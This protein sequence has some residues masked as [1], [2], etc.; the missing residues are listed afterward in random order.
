MN[1]KHRI[2]VHYYLG[3]A[4]QD[5]AKAAK[6]AG[7]KRPEAAGKMLLASKGISAYL[8]QKL[9]ESGAMPVAE[10]LGRWSDVAAF[11][12]TEFLDFTTETNKAGKEV[13]RVEFNVK[14]LRKKGLGHLI[15]KMEF[16]PSGAVKLEFH[17]SMAAKDSLAKVNGLYKQR[18]EI[19]DGSGSFPEEKLYAFIT[20]LTELT[21]PIPFGEGGGA[22]QPG[23]IC[24]GG[25]WVDVESGPAPGTDRSTP[26]LGGPEGDRS[27]GFDPRPETRQVG[28]GVEILP[29]VDAGKEAEPPGDSGVL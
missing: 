14:K 17:D 23:Q 28:D 18:I 25:E 27:I 11:D 15:K 3:E 1:Y 20:E 12:P 4:K 13:E 9:E 7:Y 2:F 5:A 16:L 10:I 6:M 26:C 22:D 24:D 8:E 21:R 19:A 29:G